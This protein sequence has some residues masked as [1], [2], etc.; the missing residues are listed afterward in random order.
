ME[1]PVKAQ[2]IDSRHLKLMK[3]IKIAP[4]STVM[5]TITAR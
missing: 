4:G 1:Q 3:P 2:V 5:V